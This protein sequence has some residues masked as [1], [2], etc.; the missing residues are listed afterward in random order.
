M[1]IVNAF[2]SEA[3]DMIARALESVV[4]VEIQI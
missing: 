4:P 3:A 2:V 1:N